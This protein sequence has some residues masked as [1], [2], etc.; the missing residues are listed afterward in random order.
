MQKFDSTTPTGVLF[1]E[2]TAEAI[3][4]AVERF[5]ANASRIT[6]QACRD[7]ARRF[8]PAR[9]DAEFLDALRGWGIVQSDAATP[10]HALVQ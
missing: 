6:P 5:E 2:Q 8:A 1:A 7:N 9:F 10:P 4:A 3:V